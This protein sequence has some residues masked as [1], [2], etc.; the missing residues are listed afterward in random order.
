MGD[1]GGGDSERGGEGGGGGKLFLFA[2][3]G[4]YLKELDVRTDS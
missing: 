3:E 4:P 1:G 2:V